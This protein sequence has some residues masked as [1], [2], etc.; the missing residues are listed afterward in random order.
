MMFARLVYAVLRRLPLA[1]DN[2]RVKSRV[3]VVVSVSDLLERLVSDSGADYYHSKANRAL[4]RCGIKIGSLHLELQVSLIRIFA[5]EALSDDDYGALCDSLRMEP[6]DVLSAQQ[7]LYLNELLCYRGR[8]VAA[9]ICRENARILVLKP[10]LDDAGKPVISWQNSIAA[11]IEGGECAGHKQL[12][13]LLSKAG[14]NGASA[15]KWH[16]LLSV[17]LGEDVASTDYA[18]F[19]RTRFFS[20]VQNCTVGVVGPAPVESQDAE[21]IDGFDL[22]VRLN[23]S[24][25][26]KGCDLVY[27]GLRTDMTYFN[28]EQVRALLNERNGVLPHEL[29]WVCLKNPEKLDAIQHSNPD[30]NFRSLISFDGMTFHGRYNMVPIVAM[31]L[32]VYKTR[33][34]RIYHTDLM[35]TPRRVK[36][37]YPDSFERTDDKMQ[38]VFLRGCIVHD[39]VLQ[40]RT[41]SRLWANGK[42]KGDIVFDGVMSMGLDAYLDALER[43]YA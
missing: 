2:W 37:Y 11:V 6:I 30:L 7:W 43:V 22:V 15:A 32:S 41:L 31:D 19:D 36:G 28:L 42:I 39:P 14:I 8:F 13:Q 9:S 17:Q 38:K 27:K 5:G 34:V 20:F 10:L 3:D 23:H 24:S 29:K 21:D 26:G 4:K 1:R 16:L 12:R 33:A 25:T 35:L 40:Y 18:E